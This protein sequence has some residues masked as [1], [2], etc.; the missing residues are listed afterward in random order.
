M[1]QL[2]LLKMKQESFYIFNIYALGIFYRN[3]LGLYFFS[4]I[5]TMI[6]MIHNSSTDPVLIKKISLKI[7]TLRDEIES[8][9]QE[10]IDSGSAMNEQNVM[11]LREQYTKKSS[12]PNN[13]IGLKSLSEL[14][15]GEDEMAK[16]MAMADADEAQEVVEEVDEEAKKNTEALDSGES[17]EQASNI[18][19][20]NANATLKNENQNIISISLEA[21]NIAEDK[22]SRGKTVLSE[23]SMEK[24]FFFCNKSFTEGQSIVIQFCIPKSFIANADI[25]YCRPFNLKSRIISQNNYTHRVLIRFNFLK[26]G[27]RAL[28]RQFLTSIEPDFSKIEKKGGGKDGDG[29]GAGFN[30]LDDLGL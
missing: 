10:Q 3:C 7:W 23:I 17:S 21:P 30:E 22:I 20:L 4:R 18:V 28:L 5:E 25:L 9:V 13:V 24:M 16:A 29:A 14:D 6:S 1:A 26:D 15:S 19:S 2:L 12:T 27:E 11:E 8:R